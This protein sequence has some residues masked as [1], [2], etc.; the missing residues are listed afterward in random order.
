MADWMTS[1]IGQPSRHQGLMKTLGRRCGVRPAI[2]MQTLRTCSVL[3]QCAYLERS[4]DAPLYGSDLPRSQS[5]WGL[6][7]IR[8]ISTLEV[9]ENMRL[10]DLV[11]KI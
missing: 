2:M 9:H 4:K 8:P 7:P 11:I 6:Q 3:R 10:G 5:G 1:L